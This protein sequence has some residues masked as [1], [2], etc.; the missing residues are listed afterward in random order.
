LRK[1]IDRNGRA[2]AL[3]PSGLVLSDALGEALDVT[4]GDEVSLEW[5][6][7]NRTT[8]RALVAG[9]GKDMV[10]L[11]AYAEP[12]WLSG[13]R[14][15]L[16]S[17]NLALLSVDP[18]QEPR[19][20]EALRR[21]P[22]VAV[23]TRRSELVARF[24]RQ[25]GEMMNTFTL[26]VSVFVV[27]MALGVLQNKARVALSSRARELATMRVLGY[28]TGEAA[29]VLVGELGAH[30]LVS[31]PLGLVFG[32]RMAKALAST[33]DPERFRMPLVLAP[34]SAAFAVTLTLLAAAVTSTL[35]A[36]RLRRTAP[37]HALDPGSA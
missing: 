2:F 31:L 8:A 21:V 10:G 11:Q 14:G 9:F 15:A 22:R 34:R 5:R 36:W 23:A 33:V 1:L 28:S 27:T 24:R 19:L 6:D 12:R 13:L 25:T 32:Q 26:I 16:P 3:S 20:H 29:A 7:G 4:P 18:L 35:V 37:T 17:S 30:V